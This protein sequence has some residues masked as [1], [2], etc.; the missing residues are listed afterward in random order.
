[1]RLKECNFFKNYEGK[2]FIYASCDAHRKMV[3]LH[4]DVLV[5]NLITFLV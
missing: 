4:V 3:Y 1:M 2:T 5:P